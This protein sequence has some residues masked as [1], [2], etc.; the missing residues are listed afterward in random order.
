M[1]T[2]A[3]N[4]VSATGRDRQAWQDLLRLSSSGALDKPIPPPPPRPLFIIVG[5][6]FIVPLGCEV[7]SSYLWNHLFTLLCLAGSPS[8][9]TLGGLHRACTLNSMTEL[10]KYFVDNYL[11]THIL[12]M[13]VS[14]LKHDLKK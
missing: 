3:G 1:D 6:L 8:R 10:M 11:L 13:A 2:W 5:L 7:L 9:E 14:F 12:L 4:L